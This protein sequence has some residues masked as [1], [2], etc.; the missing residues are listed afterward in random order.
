LPIVRLIYWQ[1]SLW[2]MALD[3]DL[4][5]LDS[6]GIF[7]RPGEPIEG[8]V[9]RGWR[10]ANH[11]DADE[12]SVF[13]LIKFLEWENV[14]P[15]GDEI[16]KEAIDGLDRRFCCRP[17]Y[18]DVYFADTDFPEE[19]DLLGFSMANKKSYIGGLERQIPPFVLL[20]R[21]GIVP[22]VPRLRHEMAHSMRELSDVNPHRGQEYVGDYEEMVADSAGNLWNKWVHWRLLSS[23][24]LPIYLSAELTMKSTFGKMA[25]YVMMRTSYDE[26]DNIFLKRKLA[27][28]KLKGY[29]C[30]V[31]EEKEPGTP[32]L[33]YEIMK[34][35]LRL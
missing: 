28:K 34:E 19:K 31:A 33:K 15:A 10:I 30:E 4:I 21:K 6:L 5:K 14:S 18:V 9:F 7:P 35:R 1:V 23:K 16:V 27:G 29:I 12:S 26:M 17:T 24:A 13:S 11:T 20:N 3:S 22:Y 8:Y 32:Y 2:Q 25:D